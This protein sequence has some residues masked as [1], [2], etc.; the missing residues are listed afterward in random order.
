MRKTLLAVA[1][2]ATLCAA[3]A[4]TADRAEAMTLPLPAGIATAIGQT[5]SVDQARYVCR[6]HWNGF[7]WVRHCFW[8]PG[9][10]WGG[11]YYNR[12][13][14]RWGWRGHRWGWRQRW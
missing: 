9:P 14:P 7:R 12:W 10:Y 3:G 11:P 5:S 8:R 6:S 13:G 2:A 1:A 4:L